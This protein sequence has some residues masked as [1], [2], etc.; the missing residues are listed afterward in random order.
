M[1]HLPHTTTNSSFIVL[2]FALEITLSL[3]IISSVETIKI[4]IFG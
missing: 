3:G 2:I 1:Y 4:K